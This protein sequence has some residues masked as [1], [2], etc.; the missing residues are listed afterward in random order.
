MDDDVEKMKK[1]SWKLIK[2]NSTYFDCLQNV[3]RCHFFLKDAMLSIVHNLV[4]CQSY[5][6]GL[7]ES[8]SEW[9]RARGDL[10]LFKLITTIH[11]M[12]LFRLKNHFST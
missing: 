5:S 1:E 12:K 11:N 10:N 7:S 2:V 8:G 4:G 3:V 9:I 6:C